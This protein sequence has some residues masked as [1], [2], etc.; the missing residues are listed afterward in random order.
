LK[1]GTVQEEIQGEDKNVSA[2]Q[3][4][5]LPGSEADRAIQMVRRKLLSRLSP[6]AD[7][8]SLIFKATDEGNLSRM[9]SGMERRSILFSFSGWAPFA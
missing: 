6:E 3:P 9:Y 7:V 5:S 2:K 1:K 8:R 4:E